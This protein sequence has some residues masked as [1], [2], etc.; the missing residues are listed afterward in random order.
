MATNVSE[1]IHTL[2]DVLDALGQ[3]ASD[4]TT[5]TD[6]DPREDMGEALYLAG[7][8]M[9]IAQTTAAIRAMIDDLWAT[10]TGGDTKGHTA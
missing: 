1:R 8:L 3:Q 4:A 7:Q 9:A 5:T 6:F 2:Q 10:N